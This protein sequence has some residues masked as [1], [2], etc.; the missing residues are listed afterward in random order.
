MISNKA[1]F[2]YV[3]LAR[4]DY[5][6]DDKDQDC[7]LLNP[8][9]KVKPSIAF[10]NGIGPVVLTCSDHNKGN[11]SLMIHPCRQP[12]HILPAELSDQLCHAVIKPRCIKPMKAS[13]YSTSF[14]MH[15]QRGT[16]NGIDT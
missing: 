16:F 6:H 13:Q 2:K 8:N 10:V 7:L 3:I 5:A 14:Q 1:A 9:W 4:D 15:E 11:T 12:S